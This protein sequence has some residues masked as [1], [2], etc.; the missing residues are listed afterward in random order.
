MTG[1]SS[2]KPAASWDLFLGLALAVIAPLLSVML[3]AGA[4]LIAWA[5]RRPGGEPP[6]AALLVLGVFGGSILASRVVRRW[7]SAR[8]HSRAWLVLSGAM[9]CGAAYLGTV[10]LAP[11]PDLLSE[12]VA[13]AGQA[14]FYLEMIKPAGP[15][16][17]AG[18]AAFGV[19]RFDA[20]RLAT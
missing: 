5:V 14:R 3:V 1:E 20:Q 7:P 4:S 6:T 10:A 19:L 17:V 15:W 11:W 9:A 13:R 12:E 2:R 18:L 16:L 8:V